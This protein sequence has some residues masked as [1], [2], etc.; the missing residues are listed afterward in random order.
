MYIMFPI[1]I[2]YYFGVNLEEKFSTPDFWP[3][4]NQTHTIPFEK[5][6]ISQELAILKQR[7]LAARQ[8]RLQLESLEQQGSQQGPQDVLA[9]TPT[10]TAVSQPLNDNKQASN[11]WFSWLK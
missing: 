8:R 5:E 7:R 4:K 6:E 11:S 2:M 3:K 1:G 9:L 10:P